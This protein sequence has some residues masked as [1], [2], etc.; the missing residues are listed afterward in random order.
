MHGLQGCSKY[1]A[2]KIHPILHRMHGLYV[3]CELADMFWVCEPLPDPPRPPPGPP[4][5]T[6]SQQPSVRS[7]MVEASPDV[8]FRS[9]KNKAEHLFWFNGDRAGSNFAPDK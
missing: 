3:V 8:L 4:K 9:A 5:L 2:L 7:V 1:K 6:T